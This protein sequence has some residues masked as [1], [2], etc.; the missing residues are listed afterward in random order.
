ML[1]LGCRYQD[2]IRLLRAEL[3]KRGGIP[4]ALDRAIEGDREQSAAKR[5][6]LGESNFSSIP[7]L[8]GIMNAKITGT[9]PGGEQQLGS[10][11]TL[12]PKPAVGQNG[13][14]ADK[15]SLVALPPAAW[16]LSTTLD[17]PQVQYSISSQPSSNAC[18][19][20]R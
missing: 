10:S 11:V 9:A 17:K 4:P 14:G 3:E 13:T 19:V 12:P 8:A 2:E 6:R 15:P 18:C 1:V 7:V 16:S 20:A 5:A